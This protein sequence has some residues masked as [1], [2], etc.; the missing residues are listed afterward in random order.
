MGNPGS[1]FLDSTGQVQ[2]F[3]QNSSTF[4]LNSGLLYSGNDK[5][6]VAP[7]VPFMLFEASEHVEAIDSIFAVDETEEKMVWNN[8]AFQDGTARFCADPAG[9]LYAV[10]LGP[11]P[12][13]CTLTELSVRNRK[14]A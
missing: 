2:A 4:V 12:E 1:G 7:G 5:V 13:N 11:L 14:L 3:C 8:E 6:S 9:A 10:F